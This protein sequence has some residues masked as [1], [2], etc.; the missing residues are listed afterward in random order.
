M[1]EQLPSTDPTGANLRRAARALPSSY[2]I[3]FSA[4]AETV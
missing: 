4:R 2:Y 3:Y 1:H